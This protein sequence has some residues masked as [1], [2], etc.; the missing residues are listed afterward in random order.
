MSAERPGIKLFILLLIAIVLWLGSLF[1]LSVVHEREQHHEGVIEEV[2]GHWGKSQTTGGLLFSVPYLDKVTREVDDEVQVDYVRRSAHFLPQE[3]SLDVSLSAEKRS[4]GI[5]DVV[6]YNAEVGM[7]GV[8]PPIDPLQAGVPEGATVYW[9]DAFVSLAISDVRGIIEVQEFA[10]DDDALELSSNIP[11]TDVF[12]TGLSAPVP[13]SGDPRDEIEMRTATRERMA[14]PTRFSVRLGLNGSDSIQFL[15]LGEETHVTMQGLWS[16]PSFSGNFLPDEREVNNGDFTAYWRVLHLNRNYAQQFVGADQKVLA[17]S[18]GVK[19][20]QPVDY[21]TKTERMVKY[22]FFFIIFAFVFVFLAEV[23]AHAHRVHPIQYF[24]MGSALVVEYTLQL[25]LSEYIGFDWAY[26]VSSATIIAILFGYGVSMLRDRRHSAFFSAAL[27]LFYGYMYIVLSLEDLALL[28][29]SI[30]LLCIL[31]ALMWFT[32]SIDWYRY[33]V[34][35][36]AGEAG[37]SA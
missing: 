18:F 7:Q 23:R 4:R 26:L 27:A 35:D 31:A 16:A 17:S 30:G 5:Y 19:L 14:T 2:S 1:A 25:S 36:N 13:V 6:V 32:R 37:D 10:L 20:F 15:P 34:R 9:E 21:Y 22:A 33:A 11:V 28:A 3:V 12:A 8:L 29:G 24:L